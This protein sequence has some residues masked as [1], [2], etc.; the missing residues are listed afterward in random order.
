MKNIYLLIGIPG[1]GKSHWLEDKK[2]SNN[3]VLDDI[4]Q[5]MN[6]LVLLDKA[7][8]DNS[9]KNIYIAD[10]NFLEL[11][12]LKKAQQMIEEKLMNKNHKIEY[13]LFKSNKEI[14]EHNVKLRNDGRNVSATI[15][16]FHKNY[17][18]I[19]DYLKDKQV[20]I[21]EANKYTKIKKKFK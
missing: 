17:P 15:Q 7:I 4:S 11:Q 12:V 8:N 21:I 5:L 13:V 16:R 10:V 14:S 1:S 9:I 3:C 6:P 2:Q 20:N 18:T 19:I